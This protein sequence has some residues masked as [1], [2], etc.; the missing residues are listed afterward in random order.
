MKKHR[1]ILYLLLTLILSSCRVNWDGG[2][3]STNSPENIPGAM[4]AWIKKPETALIV[5]QSENNYWIFYYG[6]SK[7]AVESNNIISESVETPFNAFDT[8]QANS[9][10]IN[11]IQDEDWEI[12]MVEPELFYA[13]AIIDELNKIKKY[14]S[15]K[16][17]TKGS[18]NPSEG[19]IVYILYKK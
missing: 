11:R 8:A 1:A 15:I 2:F 10:I 3:V 17:V 16:L 6:G 5:E 4:K 7:N 14:K 9:A 18:D 19:K 12:V 13:N